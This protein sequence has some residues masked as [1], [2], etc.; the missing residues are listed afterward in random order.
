MSILGT[1][2]VRTED[3]K[4]LTAGGSYT[5]AQVRGMQFAAA[6]TVSSGSADFSFA[7]RDDGGTA[8]GGSDTLLQSM[9]ITVANQAPVLSGANPLPTLLE[10]A[11]SNDGA[12]VADLVSGRIDDP[13]GTHGI[14]VVGAANANGQWQYS[15]DGGATWQA[16][17]G[18]G[19]TS[20]FRSGEPSSTGCGSAL[21]TSTLAA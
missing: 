21:A 9:T 15:V 10:D 3:P 17:A 12:L 8:N 4:L 2:V 18:V 16:F 11:A 6:G 7:V 19:T 14:A 1:R 20:G 13:R 5:L